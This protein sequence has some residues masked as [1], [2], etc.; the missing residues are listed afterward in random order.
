MVLMAKVR[1]T[2]EVNSMFSRDD[3]VVVGVSGG[4]DSVALLHSLLGLAAR[5]GYRLH[6]AHLNHHLR[7]ADSDRDA[8]FVRDLAH[9]WSLPATVESQDIG[10]LRREWRLGVEEAARLARYRFFA[11]LVEQLGAD[12]VA[13]GHNAD[14]QV[15]TVVLHWLRGAGLAGL[16]GIRPV[17]Y[18]EVGQAWKRGQGQRLSLKV[19]RPLLKATRQEV[20]SYIARHKLASRVDATNVDVS[21]QRNRVRLELL[22]YLEQYN[23]QFRQAALRTADLLAQ[24]YDYIESKV[25]E[26]WSSLAREEDGAVVISLDEWTRLPASLQQHILR[27]GAEVLLGDLTDISAKNVLIAAEA[28]R[29]GTVGTEITLPRELRVVKGYDD[30]RLLLGEPSPAPAIIG[31]HKLTIPGTTS[32]PEIGWDVVSTVGAQPCPTMGQNPWHADLDGDAAGPELFVR[33]RRPGDVF[34]PL[35]MRQTKKLQ[36]F[37]VDAKVPRRTRDEVP[38][39]A[40]PSRI[41]WV[42]G[43]RIDDRVKITKDT[44]KVLCLTFVRRDGH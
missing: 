37:F 8:E 29:G 31:E 23:P 44:Q 7:G 41:V 27:R 38:I 3:L 11:E 17:S 19:V 39:V 42:A 43:M 9:G 5:G 1:Q 14:D 20:E 28:M 12:C 21:L 18:L 30:F 40:S 25:Q 15:E 24:D 26:A 36:D 2:I 6:V 13:V 10:R 16:R 34:Q 22:P 4:P 33:G 35:G 32:I